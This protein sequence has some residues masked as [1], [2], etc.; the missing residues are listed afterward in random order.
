MLE[1]ILSEYTIFNS[2]FPVKKSIQTIRNQSIKIFKSNGIP[3]MNNEEWKYSNLFS[4]FNQDFQLI[5]D[6]SFSV[7]YDKLKKYSFSQL[8]SNKIVFINGVFNTFL[9]EI[10]YKEADIF[11]LSY[12]FK[13]KK[14]E[15]IIQSYYNTSPNQYE[16][17]FALNTAF[18][19]EG[20]YI[21][22]KKNTILSKPIE[23]INFSFSENCFSIIQP[24]IFILVEE[25]SYI[26]II[27]HHQSIEKTNNLTN[28]VCEIFVKKNSQV[29]IY[30]IQNDTLNSHLIDNT[31][32]TQ[33]ENS[34]VKVYTFSI[35]GKFTRNN[36][37]VYQKGENANSILN[38]ITVINANQFVDHHTLIHHIYPNCKSHEFYRGVFKNSTGVFNGK[39][40]VNQKAQK[41]NAFQ[42]NDNLILSKF[43]KV[44]TNPQLQ[45][46]ADDVKCS[47]GC[48]IGQL[49]EE[50]L[51]YF[52][53]RG[54]SRKKAQ[55]LLVMAFA[56]EILKFVKVSQI[57]NKISDLIKNK[58]NF[59]KH[60]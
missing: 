45:I 47:H 32:I 27:E 54:I 58:L 57:K 41:V 7:N 44:N 8:E 25:N 42:K 46:F 12:A 31:S 21:H 38:G 22:I 51:F 4:F 40:I 48:T 11:S 30:K 3:S 59:H 15:A 20:C 34:I 43:A 17:L 56:N 18:S 33:E 19:H 16:T 50:V 37:N 9:S 24:R 28:Y 35:G 49:N 5:F 60:F 14:Y 55:G 6:E 10:S 2:K 39:I 1:K 52:Q 36:L 26:Q 23:I 53:T 29:D 13:E